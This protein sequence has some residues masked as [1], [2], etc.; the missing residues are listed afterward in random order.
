MER[1]LEEGF[2]ARR[3]G[4][5]LAFAALALAGCGTGEPPDP[6]AVLDRAITAGWDRVQVQVGV[7]VQVPAQQNDGFP[8]PATS[9]NV[10]PS[11]IGATIDTQTGQF[12]GLVS[13]PLAAVGMDP[14]TL[15]PLAPLIQSLDA[16]V[17]YDGGAVYAKSPLLPMLGGGFGALGGRAVNGD[18]TGWV[19]LASRVDVEQM[20]T[21]PL[22]AVIGGVGMPGV[23]PLPSAGDAVSLKGFI[24][25]FGIG[26]TF[27]GE[28]STNGIETQHLTATLN[29]ARLAESRQ[30]AAFTGFGRDQLQGIFDASRT[31]A[32]TANLWFDK[33]NGRLA[34]FRLDGTSAGPPA[35]TVALVIQ[36]SEPAAGISFEAPTAFADFPLFGFPQGP[37]LEA[38]AAPVEPELPTAEL[39]TA[40]PPTDETPAAP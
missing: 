28:E 39:P 15:G 10:D 20:A 21:N 7:S 14:S 32:V 30:L 40:D 5:V 37:G 19:K 38:T 18:L 4:L 1:R 26:V 24:E 16:E 9:I 34:T 23:L 33:G 2:M 13:V 27:V 3:I 12:R 35:T 11:S 8:I 29:F 25:D 36:L 31:V 17:L 6:Y 22:G